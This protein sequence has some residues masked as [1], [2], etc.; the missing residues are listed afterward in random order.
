MRKAYTKKITVLAVMVAIIGGCNILSNNESDNSQISVQ[1]DIQTLNKRLKIVNQEI[2]L[3]STRAKSSISPTTD[4]DKFIHL[5]NVESP[6]DADGNRLSATS[7]EIRAN[8]VYVS[9][10]LNEK[11]SGTAKIYA[12]AIDII[13]MNEADEPEIISS[14][15]FEDTDINAIE[16]EENAKLIWLTGG[17][18]V[19]SSGYET[20]T[21]NGAVLGELWIND[22]VFVDDNYRE[23]PLP[24]F[25]G[26]DIVDQGTNL[27]VSSGATGG[28][29]YEVSKSGLEV[30][31]SF[32]YNYAKS[33]DKREDDIIG[34]SIT[35]SGEAQFNMIDFSSSSV[36]E[37]TSGFSVSPVD[38]KNV[39][40]HRDAIT[41]AA[42]GNLGVKGYKFNDSEPLFYEYNAPGG[43]AANGVTADGKYVYIA[44]GTDGLFITTNPKSGNKEP[45]SVY[46]WDNGSGSANFVKT[47][48]RYIILANG[49][50]GL[51]IL[52]K[53]TGSD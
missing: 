43:D 50:D 28:G 18:N 27:Y 6:V 45:E 51:N 21:H 4:G 24:S 49:T 53:K 46:N 1:N 11:L 31:Q 41:Y 38:G 48:G 30:L 25:S 47:D 19:S 44:N 17:R 26:N 13:D 35:P 9:Y 8:K 5:A 33:I 39:I 2:I 16:I 34:L 7:I 3:D 52:K 29:F 22:D 32:S 10:H 23:I 40:E 12:G 42:M 20:G 36:N 37:F 14:V 15:S